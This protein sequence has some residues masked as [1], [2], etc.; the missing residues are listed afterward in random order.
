M[1][2]KKQKEG[3]RPRG[4]GS[5][6][7]KV[8]RGYVV[9]PKVVVDGIAHRGEGAGWR[10]AKVDTRTGSDI[11]RHADPASMLRTYQH[12]DREQMSKDAWKIGRA[13]AQPTKGA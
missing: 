12:P 3:H 13:F 9:K 2:R 8:S 6:V 1:S 10:R 7:K 11:L 5:V 4:F